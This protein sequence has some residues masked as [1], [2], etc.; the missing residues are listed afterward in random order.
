MQLKSVNQFIIHAKIILSLLCCVVLL[1]IAE[2]VWY[3]L[4]YGPRN[5][6]SLIRHVKIT[7]NQGR[8]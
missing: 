8:V 3:T 2:I 4:N 6:I 5:E 7:Y 1:L